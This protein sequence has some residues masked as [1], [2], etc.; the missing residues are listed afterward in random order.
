[1][2]TNLQHFFRIISEGAAQAWQQLMANK[3]RSFLSILGVTIGIFCIIG[4][5]SAV[6]SLEANIRGSLQKLGED[7]IYV[8]KF[9]WGEDPGAN[10][11]KWMRRPNFSFGEYEALVER[12]KSASKIG[13]W[14]FLGMKTLKWRSSST[15]NVFILG[16]T[17]DC[18]DLFGLEFSGG[19]Y[20]SPLEYQNGSDV[21]ILGAK[22]A[23]GLFGEGIDPV[24]KMVNVGGRKLRVIGVLKESGKDILKPFNFDNGA[25]VSYTLARRGFSIRRKG[26]FERTSILVKAAPG[27]ALD[28]MKD[29]I[30]GVMRAER[31]LRP[32][33]ENNFALNTLSILSGLFDNIFQTINI[34]GF[35]IGIF[36]LLVGMFSVAN[37]M[38]VSVKE[39]TNIIGIKMALGAKRWFILLEILIEAVV[40]CLVGGAF[41][42]LFIWAGAY[43]ITKAIDFEIFLSWNNMIIGVLTSVA[44][45]VISGM[46]PA[47]QASRM[48]P[49]EAIR[50][51]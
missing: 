50:A 18:Y 42:L 4:V 40:L 23:D 36:A 6:D 43:I 34:A 25:L 20:F 1:M 13:Y 7:V 5:K 32:R 24:D 27:V 22:I 49:V 44:V 30:T 14:Q 47:L 41:G 3:L 26:Q 38:F 10:Y 9:S 8:E 11:W 19:R 45:G 21:I 33:E 37:I 28:D 2:M 35:I 51:K 31:R 15:E 39:R 17:E 29:E 16:I 46:I 12:L 48:D